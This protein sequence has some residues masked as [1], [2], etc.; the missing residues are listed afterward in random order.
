MFNMFPEEE[1]ESE[2]EFKSLEDYILEDLTEKELSAVRGLNR[3]KID[4][5]P[6][7]LHTSSDRRLMNYL[8]NKAITNTNNRNPF[9]LNKRY[10]AHISQCEL[11]QELYNAYL[12]CGKIFKKSKLRG[13][14]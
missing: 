3:I 13:N 11:C 9:K 8:S 6:E 5:E 2:S 7:H 1:P 10:E 14:I 4:W 12:Q